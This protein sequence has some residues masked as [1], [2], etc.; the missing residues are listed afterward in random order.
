M[1][2]ETSK[3]FSLDDELRTSIELIKGGLSLLQEPSSSEINHHSL[4]LLLSSGLERLLKCYYLLAYEADNGTFPDYKTLKD[5]GHNLETLLKSI[6]N[7]YYTGLD[8]SKIKEEYD[9]LLNDPHLKFCIQILSNFGYQG[10]Y[11]NLNLITNPTKQFPSPNDKWELFEQML[12][13]PEITLFNNKLSIQEYK[14][15]VNSKINGIIERLVRAIA[16]QFTLGDHSQKSKNMRS[17]SHIYTEFRNLKD[18]NLGKNN[19]RKWVSAN[20]K[21][22]QKWKKTLKEKHNYK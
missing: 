2:N 13:D 21:L 22:K 7:E 20:I 3:F 11:Y 14:L 10:R 4:M 9:F 19:Y 15:A 18:E 5:H 16:F 12:L 8:R 1:V 17:L 6:I